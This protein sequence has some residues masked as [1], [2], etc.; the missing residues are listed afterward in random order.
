LHLSRGL[1]AAGHD[2]MHLYFSGNNTPKGATERPAKDLL[3]Q[4]RAIEL[5]G[6]FRKLSLLERRGYDLAYGRAAAR[7]VTDFSPHVVVSANTPLDAQA[8]LL[9][10][11]HQVNA[12]F[13]FWL[14][15]IYHQ[16]IRFVL[17]S[18][19]LP[20]A[21]LVARYYKTVER[22][23]L[24]RSDAIVCIAPEFLNTL[25]HW[26]IDS[27]KTFLIENWAPL[28]EILPLP[29]DNEW[30]REHRLDGKFCFVY[31]GTLGMKHRPAL[32]LELARH[33]QT[34]LD[35]RTVVVGA[36]AGFA[37]LQA[38]PKPG[39]LLLLPL[40]PYERVSEVL[41]AA[42]VL[43][44]ILDD[45][46][47]AFSVP[48]KTLAYLCARRPLL[49]AAPSG[50]LASALIRRTSSGIAVPSRDVNGF[51]AAATGFYHDAALRKSCSDNG[52]FHAHRTFDSR[53]ILRQFAQ[54]F[55][56]LNLPS[57]VLSETF[58]ESALRA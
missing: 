48:S 37:W 10:A 40:Q 36:G 28:D 38:R 58:N 1:A 15:D 13:V 43:V 42:G 21:S 41:A 12:K 20:G 46:C 33:F 44:A 26:S 35:V 18:R 19:G 57:S 5:P 23:L 29:Q 9:S 54:V 51:L 55:D 6:E 11:A 49:V 3:L 50:N 47:G 34:N 24:S 14:Q 56:S 52:Y 16:A 53:R 4:V 39:S 2:V 8:L 7:F 32:L 17:K 31:S 30:S 27:E 25:Q 45:D 22:R